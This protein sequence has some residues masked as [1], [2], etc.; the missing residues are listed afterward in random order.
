MTPEPYHLR[1]RM[2]P[3]E[4]G[5][6]GY[7]ELCRKYGMAQVRAWRAMGGRK[8]NPT[9]HEAI[10]QAGTDPRGRSKGRGATAPRSTRTGGI[11]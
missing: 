6:R 1:P 11:S 7:V 8:P 10:L 9:Y 3:Q 4:A 5:A 2:T